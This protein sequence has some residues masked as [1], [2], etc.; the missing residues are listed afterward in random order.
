MSDVTR[1]SR[2]ISS[3]VVWSPTF[4]DG[5]SDNSRYCGFLIDVILVHWDTIV[6][7]DHTIDISDHVINTSVYTHDR[8]IYSDL[9]TNPET[10]SERTPT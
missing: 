7:R 2:I 1:A 10:H 9:S 6:D 4:T 3:E 5:L 8:Y